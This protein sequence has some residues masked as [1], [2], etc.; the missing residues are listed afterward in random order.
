MEVHKTGPSHA[1]ESKGESK[2]QLPRWRLILWFL[3]ALLGIA[4]IVW[5][6]QD[7]GRDEVRRL[8]VKTAPWLPL[9][10]SVEGLR[11]FLEGLGT[12]ILVGPRVPWHAM[13]RA[14]LVGHAM[15]MSLPAGRATGEAVKA[16]MLSKFIGGVDAVRTSFSTHGLTLMASGMVAFCCLI[17]TAL[18]T[19]FSLLTV[20]LSILITIAFLGGFLLPRAVEVRWLHRLMQRVPFL[21]RIG[22]KFSKD[23]VQAQTWPWQVTACFIGSRLG[24]VLIVGILC[25]PL[26]ITTNPLK[27]MVLY[28]LELSA[29]SIGELVPGQL[30]VT[31]TAFKLAAPIIGNAAT[32]LVSLALVLHVVQLFWVAVGYTYGLLTGA[33]HIIRQRAARRNAERLSTQ[34]TTPT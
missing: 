21:A 33:G 23:G 17:P 5:V 6:V 2:G 28:G 14:Q 7:T 11:V 1:E 9:A 27:V 24:Q 25:I 26:N 19:G 15:C 8:L 12:R 18:Y 20:G 34:E 3:L 10:L 29:V 30:G 16:A 4:A 31:E 22:H 32:H 13:V